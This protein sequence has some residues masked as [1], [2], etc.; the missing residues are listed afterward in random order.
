MTKT[1][2]IIEGLKI[3]NKYGH[4]LYTDND[5]IH[6]NI[7]FNNYLSSDE[8]NQLKI[9]DWDLEDRDDYWYVHWY[10]FV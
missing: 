10:I 1:E 5:T 9:L 7:K 4:V 6:V 2:Q 3:L 8:Q